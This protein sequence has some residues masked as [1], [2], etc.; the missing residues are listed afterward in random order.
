MSSVADLV[1][2]LADRRLALVSGRSSVPNAAEAI[3]GRPISGSWWKDGAGS[4]VYRLLEELEAVEPG[5]LDLVLVDSRR[6]LVHPDLVPVVTSVAGE[7]GRRARAVEALPALARQLL[8]GLEGDENNAG[9]AAG[10]AP[11]G[12]EAR[13]A[14]EASLLARSDSTHTDTG[15][16]VSII[17]IFGHLRAPATVGYESALARLVEAA[18]RSAVVAPEKE[19][20][21]WFRKVEPDAGRRRDAVDSLTCSRLNGEGV[22]WLAAQ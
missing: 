21:G 9:A 5:Y 10:Q 4:L 2:W 8:A 13:S 3:V 19:V 11:A 6:T 14:L 18:L 7:P 16:H 17:E 1:A 20:L 15:R 22:V 12:R